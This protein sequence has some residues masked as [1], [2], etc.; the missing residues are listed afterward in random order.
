MADCTTCGRSLSDVARFCPVCGTPV[1]REPAAPETVVQAIAPMR[2]PIDEAQ[3]TDM[4]PHE[5]VAVAES[6]PPAEVLTDPIM[7]PVV[8]PAAIMNAAVRC[9]ACGATI[10]EGDMFCG[11][12]GAPVAGIAGPT[13]GVAASALQSPPP[14]AAHPPQPARSQPAAQPA[15]AIY[16]PPHAGGHPQ[17]RGAGSPLAD[18]LSFSTLF[19]VGNAIAVFWVAEGVNLLYWILN[20]RSHR[21]AG[22]EAFL[23]SVAGFCLFA[24]LIRIL[25]EVAVTANRTADDVAALR[26]ERGDV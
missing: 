3:P 2:T 13:P 20:W 6:E 25:V 19:T 26:E 4:Q 22:S 18:Y 16:H 17:A 23:W 12:C 7:E 5:P 9:Q 11:D 21:Y 8:E 15:S 1:A 14:A 10:P 24:V